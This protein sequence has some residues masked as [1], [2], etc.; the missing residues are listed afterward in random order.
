MMSHLYETGH[1]HFDPRFDPLMIE[2][3]QITENDKKKCYD[4]FLIIT[5][6]FHTNTIL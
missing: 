1:T 4:F 5:I 3:T 2:S 6:H